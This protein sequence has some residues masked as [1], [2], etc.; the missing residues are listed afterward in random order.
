MNQKT[1]LKISRLVL[2]LV[3]IVD[4]LKGFMHTYNVRYVAEEKAGIEPIPDSLA[5]FGMYGISNIL[6]GCIFILIVTKAPKLAPY[7]LLII[8]LSYVLGG[9]GLKLEEV[10]WESDF[11]GRN[12]MSVYLPLCLLTAVYY[13]I[14]SF[15]QR[16]S[17]KK[18]EKGPG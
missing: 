4:L 1:A 2:L 17:A 11:K 5:L 10:S 18:A 3:A 7:I 12:L 9:L 6:T 8:P 13:F 15:L 14:V 16:S